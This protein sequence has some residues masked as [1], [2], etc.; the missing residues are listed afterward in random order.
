MDRGAWWATVHG[1]AESW[2][3]LSNWHF[4]FTFIHNNIFELVCRYWNPLQ[5]EK[6]T[7]NNGMLPTSTQTP[8]QLD[9]NIDDTYSCSPHHQSVRR[10]SMSW[11]LSLNHCYKTSHYLLQVRTHNFEDIG[12]L[13]P[14]LPGKIIKLFFSTSTKN[15]SPKF[16][17][18]L[19]QRSWVFSIDI[20]MGIIE[21]ICW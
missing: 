20:G 18:A 5:V 3:Q 2:T 14:S 13:W 16:D 17:S 8:D 11:S 12:S 1:I 10:L 15:F 4:H 19:V 7:I 21:V 9:L 6:L